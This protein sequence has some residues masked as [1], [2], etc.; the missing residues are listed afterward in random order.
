MATVRACLSCTES[1]H[2]REYEANVEETNSM[3]EREEEFVVRVLPP[4]GTLIWRFPGLIRPRCTAG[5]THRMAESYYGF[6]LHD[7]KILHNLLQ[8]QF[9]LPFL[10]ALSFPLISE[11]DHLSDVML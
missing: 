3:R 7:A 6:K 8:L 11:I 10:S 9:S 5:A 1:F 2:H 4:P